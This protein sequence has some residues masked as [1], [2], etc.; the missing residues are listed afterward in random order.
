MLKNLSL[1]QR[2]ILSVGGLVF[3]GLVFSVFVTVKQSTDLV[4]SEALAKAE[5]T[6]KTIEKQIQSEID[7]VFGLTRSM[8]KYLVIAKDNNSVNRKVVMDWQKSLLDSNAILFGVGSYFEPNALDGKDKDFMGTAEYGPEGR[9]AAWIYKSNGRHELQP[10]EVQEM[11]TP[12]IGDWY[13][14]P[15]KSKKESMIEPYLYSLND[16]S[17]VYIM[18]PSVPILYKD[19]FIGLASFDIKLDTLQSYIS[20]IKPYETGYVVL[21]SGDR[22]F[23]SHPNKSL[24]GQDLPSDAFHSDVWGSVQ[25]KES[26]F[27]PYTDEVGESYFSYVQPVIVGQTGQTWGLVVMVPRAKLLAG[28]HS[29]I[30]QVLILSVGLLVILMLAIYFISHKVSKSIAKVNEVLEAT[31]KDLN[32]ASKNLSEAS[33][34][35]ASGTSETAASLEET[36]ASVEELTGMVKL[37]SETALQAS[38]WASNAVKTA[39][40]GEEKIGSLIDSINE[41]SSHSKKMEEIVNVIDDIAFQTNLLALNA[42]VEAARAGEQGKGFA[43]VAD[44]VRSLAGKSSQSAKEISDLISNSLDK[45]SSSNVLADSSGEALK[46]IIEAVQKVNSLNSE[47]SM[48]SQEQSQALTQISTAMQQIDRAVQNTAGTTSQL[49]ESCT[50]LEQQAQKLDDSVRTLSSVVQGQKAS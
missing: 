18:T 44:A 2:L 16:G 33:E 34:G 42:A 5:Q 22:K 15:K 20:N 36:V 29:F 31:G 43:V 14:I 12:G 40:H 23:I 37:N 3:V 35:L 13:L 28:V 7:Y 27:L 6:A 30:W 25:N 17:Q 11:E 9:F 32:L 41:L 26:R 19:E 49:N 1:S 39:K 21:V 24:I 4:Q 47:I 38:D 10:S 45:V 50:H 46:Q 48:A 8:A